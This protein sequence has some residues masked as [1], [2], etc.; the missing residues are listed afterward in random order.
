MTN[1]SD[2][3]DDI[4]REEYTS[5][6]EGT[7]DQ[8]RALDALVDWAT[9]KDPRAAKITALLGLA[10]TG[11]TTVATELI[12]RVRYLGLS[13]SVCAPTGKAASV[14]RRK[15][16]SD[17]TTLHRAIYKLEDDTGPDLVWVRRSNARRAGLVIVDEASMVTTEM[18]KDLQVVFGRILLVGDP[19]QLPPVGGDPALSLTMPRHTLT[20]IHRQAEESGII[21]FAHAVRAGESPLTALRKVGG[22]DVVKGL[23]PEGVEVGA[24]IAAKNSTR[25]SANAM[26]RVMRGFSGRVPQE[27]ERLMCL[28]NRA[29]DGWCNGMVCVVKEVSYLKGNEYA[30]VV[31]EC[32]DGEERESNVWIEGLDL[33][34]MPRRDDIPRGCE[35]FAWGYAVTAHKSQGSEWPIV[36][37]LETWPVWGKTPEEKVAAQETARRWAYTAAT[38]A[39]QTLYWGG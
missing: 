16:C 8:N 32:D 10:G 4:T 25:V 29:D 28:R 35:P 20:K 34:A 39:K 1:I 37:V 24:S 3:F 9:S 5:T 23:A 12:N 19:G 31:A 21:R 17:A 26:A 6:F 33:E 7:E 2:D 30:R 14:L 15:G 18:L 36:E 27:G 11:K 22:K 13:T 38:R